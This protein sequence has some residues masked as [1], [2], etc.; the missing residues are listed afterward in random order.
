MLRRISLLI[1]LAAFS[2]GF[3]AV[4]AQA[5]ER[6]SGPGY[7]SNAPSGWHIDK[8]SGGG[9]RM[10]TITPPSHTMNLRDSALISIAVTSVKHAEKA[11]HTSIRNKTKMVQ[12]LMSIPTQN[13]FGV[14]RSFAPRPTTLRHKKGVQYGVHYNYNGKGS[15]HVATLV[16]RGK[17]IYLLQVITDEDLPPL[18]SAAANMVSEDWRWR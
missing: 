14:E 1:L 13:V 9:W 5:K 11:S 8:S 12:K 16:R 15:Q 4:A 18:S 3:L 6:I 10:V 7:R 2:G 17:R